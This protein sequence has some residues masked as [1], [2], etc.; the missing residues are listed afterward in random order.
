[1]KILFFALVLL[2]LLASP[3]QGLGENCSNDQTCIDNGY[4]NK[5]LDPMGTRYSLACCQYNGGQDSTCCDTDNDCAENR[6]Y[7]CYAGD[8]INGYTD[9]TRQEFV[10][11]CDNISNQQQYGGYLP[12]PL[13]NVTLILREDCERAGTRNNAPEM[14]LLQNAENV[15]LDCQNHKLSQLETGKNTLGIGSP[16]IHFPS[17]NVTIKNCDITSN[18]HGIVINSGSNNIYIQDSIVTTKKYG[19]LSRDTDRIEVINNQVQSTESAAI[20]LETNSRN[21]NIHNNTIQ[22]KTQGISVDTITNGA[23]NLIRNNTLAP[24]SGTTAIGIRIQDTTSATL[25]ISNN[26][27]AGFFTGIFIDRSFNSKISENTISNTTQTGIVLINDATRT[28]V[29]NNQIDHAATGISINN[30]PYNSAITGNTI[31]WTKTGLRIVN[32]NA[33][34]FTNNTL[35]NIEEIGIMVINSNGNIFEQTRVRVLAGFTGIHLINSPGTRIMNA[36]V[37]GGAVNAGLKIENSNDVGISGSNTF[38]LSKI[39]LHAMNCTDLTIGNGLPT[40]K[41]QIK[42]NTEKGALIENCTNTGITGIEFTNNPIGLELLTPSGNTGVLDNN[43]L[44]NSIGLCLKEYTNFG[45]GNTNT[46]FLENNYFSNSKKNMRISDTCDPNASYSGNSPPVTNSADLH[47]FDFY[48]QAQPIAR[49]NVLGGNKYL[50]NVWLGTAADVYTGM[51]TTEPFDT[52]GDTLTPH[53]IDGLGSDKFPLT[54]RTPAGP[55]NPPPNNGNTCLIPEDCDDGNPC[56]TDECSDV[57]CFYTETVCPSGQSCSIESGFC[58]RDLGILECQQ[59]QDCWDVGDDLCT[60]GT[61]INNSCQ[62]GPKTCP[63][64]QTCQNGNCEFAVIPIQNC[65]NDTECLN[66]DGLNCT[67][68]TCDLTLGQCAPNPKTCDSG[69]T[70]IEPRGNCETQSSITPISVDETNQLLITLSIIA[71]LGSI[72]S[73]NKQAKK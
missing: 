22:G 9:D 50:G 17:N 6:G 5:C 13:E 65:Q 20:R 63:G 58:E 31:T 2:V 55:G 53:I 18:N 46:F 33:N 16:S 34:T 19:I 48:S 45:A 56:T 4:G 44:L 28:E 3:V 73:N 62:Y 47:A 1:M 41:I 66:A 24:S 23:Y 67:I 27:I 70:C 35:N 72:Y 60:V 25:E 36:T 54:L 57:G 21:F 40:E 30:S 51:D 26:R 49:T 71:V 64:N 14:L 29:S 15:T 43:F 69:L 37:S 61:C 39:G 8:C 42:N 68:E 11:T 12:N 32:S 52:V 38:E 7:F 59:N 10:L